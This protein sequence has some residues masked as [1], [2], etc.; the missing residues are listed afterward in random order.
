MNEDQLRRAALAGHDALDGIAPFLDTLDG[1]VATT[2]R[3]GFTEDQ[4]R[5]IVAYMFGWRAADGTKPDG[6]E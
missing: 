3:R 1:F 5:A 6:A 4:A 2:K